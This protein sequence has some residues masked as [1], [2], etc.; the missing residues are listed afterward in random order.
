MKMM[1]HGIDIF[2][3]DMPDGFVALRGHSSALPTWWCGPS[4]RGSYLRRLDPSPRTPTS[5]KSVRWQEVPRGI[6]EHCWPA[7]CSSPSSGPGLQSAIRFC[8]AGRENGR[9]TWAQESSAQQTPAP[10]YKAETETLFILLGPKTERT[11]GSNHQI[12]SRLLSPRIFS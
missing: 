9:Q 3:V 4:T 5:W 11:L 12:M 6:G 7:P 10:V 1:K 2:M 8:P